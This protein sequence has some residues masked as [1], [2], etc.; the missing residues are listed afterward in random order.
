MEKAVVICGPTASGKTRLSIELAKRLGGEIIS[1]DSMQIYK[2]MDIGTSKP[3][4]KEQAG[5]KHYMLDICEPG[6][7]FSVAAYSEMA[8]KC[9]NEIISHGKI[10]IICGGTGLYINALVSGVTFA[11][12]PTNESIRK[13]LMKKAEILGGDNLLD[14][15]FKV[16]PVSA[17]KL[18]PNDIKRIVRALEV[19]LSSGKTITWYNEQSK[20][21]PPRFDARFIGIMPREREVLYNRIDLRVDEMMRK[22]LLSEVKSL[23]ES[24]KLRG[25][26]AQAIGYKEFLNHIIFGENL[27]LAVDTVKRK[28]RNYAKR[29]ITWFKADE[30]VKFILYE[31]NE[32][33]DDIVRKSTNY[34][35]DLL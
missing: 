21:T 31:K 4:L 20:K 27:S 24:G 25:T 8:Y 3:T 9:F 33:F 17:E 12:K 7:D 2:G 28:T 1:A 14:E 15:L 23:Y 11:A 6:E 22:G 32:S 19:Y 13:K 26:A 5:I 16:D 30:R 29:Q 18:Y 35:K 34:L 10:P